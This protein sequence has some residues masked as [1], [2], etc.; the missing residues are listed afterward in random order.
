MVA[1]WTRETGHGRAEWWFNVGNI[2][3]RGTPVPDG[4]RG[5]HGVVQ[6]L[7]DGKVYRA[8]DSV[9]DGIEDW[10]RLMEGPRAQGRAGL[11]TEAWRYLVKSG[12]GPGWYARVL[13]AGY[14]PYSDGAVREFKDVV[15]QLTGAAA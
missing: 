4:E 13:R 7:A 1:Q 11:Y 6:R 5:W 9:E 10:L 2:K 15:R 3:G 14:S 12:D 8:Y